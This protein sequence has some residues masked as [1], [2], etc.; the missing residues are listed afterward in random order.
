MGGRDGGDTS[1]RGPG[2]EILLADRRRHHVGE[3][4][5]RAGEGGHAECGEPR[6]QPAVLG[7]RALV[8]EGEQRHHLHAGSNE[9]LRL[10]EQACLDP[11]LVEV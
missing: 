4:I 2:V 1:A 8:G 9:A 10:G 5:R 6:G 11:A 3:V 7:R